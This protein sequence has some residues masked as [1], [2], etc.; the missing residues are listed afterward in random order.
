MFTGISS[1]RRFNG[2][3][4]IAWHTPPLAN[5]SLRIDTQEA[6]LRHFATERVV[7]IGPSETLANMMRKTIK[8]DFATE[9][10]ALGLQREILSYEKDSDS[11]YY[12]I[13]SGEEQ[14]TPSSTQTNAPATN[15][16]PVIEPV[17]TVTVA[18]TTVATTVRAEIPDTPINPVDTV[19]VLMSLA[20]K[21]PAEE[22]NRTQTIKALCGGKWP[23]MI[24]S[25]KDLQG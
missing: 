7:E 17:A 8:G 18:K 24:H 25:P 13:Q 5:K 14:K 2:K 23:W 16:A 11:I 4:K 12:T 20:L 6:I 9:D 22:I 15:T 21:K 1:A 19:I 3:C 10:M